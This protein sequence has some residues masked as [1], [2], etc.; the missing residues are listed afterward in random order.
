MLRL[1]GRI[2]KR[3]GWIRGAKAFGTGAL[4]L[5]AVIVVTIALELGG[6]VNV[7]YGGWIALVAS[8][9]AFLGS[10]LLTAG[11][12]PNLD[13]VPK[14]TWLEIVTIAGLLAALLFGAAYALAQDDGGTFVAVLVYLGVLATA[15][16]RT[17]FG[18]WVSLAGRLHRNV[19]VASAF[20]VAFF[21]PFTQHGSDANMSIATQVLIFAATAVGLNI[22]VGL[23]GLLDLGYIAF[24][25]AG[26]FTAAVLSESAFATFFSRKPPFIVVMLIAGCISAT[27]GLICLLYTSRR[28]RQEA[29]R[30]GPGR[31]LR[32][33]VHQARRHARGQRDREQGRQGL[34]RRHHQHEGQ[35]PAARLLRH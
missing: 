33:G 1:L 5:V 6:A 35:E 22:V 26:A 2:S 16:L 10:R 18:A 28:Q 11:R 12:E 24:L 34:L 32:Q 4:V 25:G 13:R 30:P 3:F 7:E 14:Y 29:L 8:G 23:A 9:L 15:A 21:F 27:L 31:G 20:A 19:L 17:G